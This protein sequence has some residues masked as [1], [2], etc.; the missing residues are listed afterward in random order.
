MQPI[1]Y[2]TANWNDLQALLQGLRLSVL[3]AWRQHGPGTTREVSEKSGIDILTFRPRTTELY[4]LGFIAI[5]EDSIPST[6]QPFN[7]SSVP[8][9]R[10]HEGTYRALSDGEAWAR[11][12][13]Q[14]EQAQDAQLALKI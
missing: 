12:R 9:C 1:D 11:F 4:Q 8:A 6:V 3:E 10:G 13:E 14:R 2:R 7:F 5:V